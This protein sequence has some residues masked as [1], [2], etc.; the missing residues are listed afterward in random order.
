MVAVFR[1]FQDETSHREFELCH[2]FG[3]DDRGDLWAFMYDGQC[4]FRELVGVCV[5]DAVAHD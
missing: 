3:T 2:I 4:F 1:V 5:Q